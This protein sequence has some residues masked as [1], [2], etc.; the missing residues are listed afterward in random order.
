VALLQTIDVELPAM[1]TTP[2]QTEKPPAP[3]LTKSQ[4]ERGQP[5][6]HGDARIIAPRAGAVHD[7]GMC[8]WDAHANALRRLDPD[9]PRL[10][11]FT[12][13]DRIVV[14]EPP[15]DLPGA[16]LKIPESTALTIQPGPYE[17]QPF[18]P[19]AP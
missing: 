5:H 1:C 16:W 11:Q 18:N 6:Q 12:N 15:G 13:G 10:Q 2:A 4:R 9:N 14:S 7:R 3:A 17:Q 19:H 8:R